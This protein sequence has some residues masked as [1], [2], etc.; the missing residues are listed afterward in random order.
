LSHVHWK[1]AS[2][3]KAPTTLLRRLHEV[4][5][6]YPLGGDFSGCRMFIA[7]VRDTYDDGSDFDGLAHAI[8]EDLKASR[9]VRADARLVDYFLHR[10]SYVKN[11]P[12]A[13]RRV[14]ERCGSYVKVMSFKD[15]SMGIV[16]AFARWRPD[17][18]SMH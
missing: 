1:Q 2:P 18:P 10:Y 14:R 13:L 9:Y 6:E 3:T 15:V 16:A 5:T 8:L 7:Q 17:S 12:Q 4:T 11:D